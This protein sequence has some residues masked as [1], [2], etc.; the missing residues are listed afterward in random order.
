MQNQEFQ[1]LPFP[2]FERNCGGVSSAIVKGP[3]TIFALKSSHENEF[4]KGHFMPYPRAIFIDN[5]TK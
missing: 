2:K 3:V 4:Y 1:C 5:F